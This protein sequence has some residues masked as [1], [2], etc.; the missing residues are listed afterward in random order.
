M[1]GKAV[2]LSKIV[3]EEHFHAPPPYVGLF[4]PE[5]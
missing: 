2:P 1:K 4:H 5:P 3:E